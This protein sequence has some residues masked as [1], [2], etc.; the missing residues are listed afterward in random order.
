[1]PTSSALLIKELGDHDRDRKK[2]KNV[3]H[4]GDL[5]LE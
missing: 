2:T 4:T 5:T 3:K 1:M